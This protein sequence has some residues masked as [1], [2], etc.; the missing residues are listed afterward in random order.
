MKN[1]PMLSTGN[2]F[3][4]ILF[5][6]YYKTGRHFGHLSIRNQHKPALGQAK[7]NSAGWPF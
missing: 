3:Q 7:D 2:Q 5:T 1:A 4:H 6:E